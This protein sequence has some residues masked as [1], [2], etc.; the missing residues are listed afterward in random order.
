MDH[1]GVNLFE[2]STSIPEAVDK[3]SDTDEAALLDQIFS[4]AWNQHVSS[5]PSA[6]V[7]VNTSSI[8]GTQNSKKSVTSP[9]G[10]A[11]N[12]NNALNGSVVNM[13]DEM[14]D[15]I[16]IGELMKEFYTENTSLNDH[17]IIDDEEEAL[18]DL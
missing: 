4:D 8:Y 9:Y 17:D 11:H 2:D 6:T 15:E 12:R 10:D 18:L 14:D 3:E 13:N 16:D 1:I 5:S 7:S